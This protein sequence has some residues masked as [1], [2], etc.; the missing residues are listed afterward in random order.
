MNIRSGR[1]EEKKEAIDLPPRDE[2][3]RNRRIPVPLGAV[4]PPLVVDVLVR[5]AQRLV[6]VGVR[7]RGLPLGRADGVV[8]G[9]DDGRVVEQVP[10]GRV[11]PVAARLVLGGDAGRGGAQDHVERPP[12][13]ARPGRLVP[14]LRVPGAVVVARQG[15]APELRDRQALDE[16]VLVQDELG[17][18][19]PRL[20]RRFHL[21]FVVC[22]AV[23]EVQFCLCFG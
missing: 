2:L 11:A 7:V 5:V 12:A 13:R 14:Q 16:R 15:G 18:R 3:Q 17:Q 9:E 10:L 8:R 20:P 23:Y 6:A 21:R 19:Q 22:A 1:G 4:L